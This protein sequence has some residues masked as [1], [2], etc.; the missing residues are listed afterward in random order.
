VRRVRWSF[1]V[2]GVAALL[3]IA[4]PATAA[5][6]IHR[7]DVQIAVQPNGD[8]HVT[9]MIAYDFGATERHGIFRN[10]PV[11][12]TWEPDASYERVFL[13]E[14]ISVSSATAPD[15]LDV[16]QDGADTV[17][18]VGD[19]DQRI[20]GE[21]TYTITYRV[22]GALNAFADDHVELYWNAIGGEWPARIE[23][24]SVRVIAPAT[25]TQL[26]CFAGPT[27]SVL[28]CDRARAEGAIARFTQDRLT[29]GEALTV[30]VALP[31]GA[32]SPRP[33]PIL[34]KRL[35]FANAFEPT[36]GAVG[37]AIAAA[38]VGVGGVA[39]LLR[40]GR[41]R[42]FRGSPVDQT[43][44]GSGGHEA[45][46]IGDA[47]T[48]A[49]VE[50]A[51]P[52]GIGP[53]EIGTLLDEQANTLD[54]TATIVD[55]AVRGHLR[56]E[57]IP[58]EGFF[59]KDDWRLVETDADTASL[60]NYERRLLS[61]LFSGRGD[62]TLSQLRRTF[63]AHLAEVQSVLYDDAVEHGWFS[64]RPD[65]VRA[66]WRGIGFVALA[67]AAWA[68]YLLATKWRLGLIG[69]PL[70]VAGLMM[71]IGAQRMPARTAKGTAL[72]RRARGFRTVIEK[73]ET[74]MSRWAESEHVFTRYL[75]YA[76][77]FGCTDKWAKA[78]ESLGDGSATATAPEWYVSS[79]PFVV[80]DFAGSI[81]DF[82][83]QTSGTITA[84]PAGS[85]TSGFSGGGSSGGGGGGGGGGS[86]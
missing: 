29:P 60:R 71:F 27:G 3:W 7:Y 34:E 42:R 9:E 26:A 65:R 53:G 14:D 15:G 11:R 78:F 75:P 55:M 13:L 49:P 59:G 62:V 23:E 73:A 43:M 37:G 41:D 36:P 52:D 22:V 12:Y 35:T 57:E 80:T 83:V 1:E 16:T 30:V 85:G 54:V 46:P 32:I 44:G 31:V 70:V 86:W 64:A 17:L 63:A 81:D 77:V 74:H 66:R 79:R 5:E 4:T 56:I 18:R 48:S 20:S 51:P 68:T 76:I 84:T 39:M 82:A 28:P 40:A 33:E 38:I 72:L 2:A 58:K 50:F 61:A 24:A 25:I 67:G 8:V 6:M 47:D 69:I 10:I 19:P 21:H 45:V